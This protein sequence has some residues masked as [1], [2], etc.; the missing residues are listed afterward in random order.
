MEN[1]FTKCIYEGVIQIQ[2]L[3]T[4]ERIEDGENV[5]RGHPQGTIGKESKT[6]RDAQ[7]ATQSQDGYNAFSILACLWTPCFGYPVAIEPV[8]YDDE[9]GESEEEDQGIVA[10]VDNVVD[11]I[12]QYP[13][14]WK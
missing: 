11:V 3:D 10:Y 1:H 7:H 12:I 4:L 5:V 2:V 8:Q 14:P 9:G 6:P 13:A